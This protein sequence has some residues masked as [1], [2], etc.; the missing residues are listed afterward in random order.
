MNT[1]RTTCHYII[2][3]AKLDKTKA[4]RGLMYKTF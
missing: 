4:S 2:D 3:Q 1:F